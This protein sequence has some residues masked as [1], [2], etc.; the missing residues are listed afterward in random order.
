MSERKPWEPLYFDANTPNLCACQNPRCAEEGK[1]LGPPNLIGRHLL[2]AIEN[3]RKWAVGTAE[4][5]DARS[6]LYELARKITD[7]AQPSKDLPEAS[8]PSPTAYA[9][10]HRELALEAVGHLTAIIQEATEAVASG[11]AALSTAIGE[12]QK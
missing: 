2:A 10:T 6:S 7:A 9:L 8:P 1:C 11:T 4:H 12:A 3:E 5:N